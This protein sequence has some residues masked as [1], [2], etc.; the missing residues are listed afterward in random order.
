[1]AK[2]VRF[3]KNL[4]VDCIDEGKMSPSQA[5][6]ITYSRGTIREVE[7]VSQLSDS[8]MNITLA[9]GILLLDVPTN[10]VIIEE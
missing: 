6:N 4:T 2:N 3:L 5:D 10:S 9:N 8:F 7:S 1:M